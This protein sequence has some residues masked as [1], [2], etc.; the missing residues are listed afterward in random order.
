MEKNLNLEKNYDQQNMI[1]KSEHCY[2]KAKDIHVRMIL[3][4]KIAISKKRSP[5][6]G[7]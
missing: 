2:E 1:E 5:F 3:Y 6:T 7:S 4:P